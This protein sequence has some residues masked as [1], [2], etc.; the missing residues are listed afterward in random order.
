MFFDAMWADPHDGVGLQQSGRGEGC[1]QFGTD[2]TAAF[3]RRSK[4]ELL[5]RSHEVPRTLRGYAEQAGGKCITVF[6]ASNY[7]GS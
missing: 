3:L 2:T 5:L 6:S 4:L 1:I 7:C